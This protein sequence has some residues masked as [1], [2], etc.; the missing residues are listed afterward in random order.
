ML[1]HLD[2]LRVNTSW[3]SSLG[4]SCLRHTHDEPGEL[5]SQIVRDESG[6]FARWNMRSD[7]A[8][9]Q[10]NLY[11]LSNAHAPLTTPLL[12]LISPTSSVIPLI[13]EHV[14]ENETDVVL[15][16]ETKGAQFFQHGSGFAVCTCRDPCGFVVDSH[17]FV[18]PLLRQSKPPPLAVSF[19]QL[20][21]KLIIF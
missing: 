19:L 20:Q 9:G 8:C 11:W 15:R 5:G 10:L 12:W 13:F 16:P 4:R 7:L 6:I 2:L 3:I 18:A 1:Q 21:Q 17:C 14:Y